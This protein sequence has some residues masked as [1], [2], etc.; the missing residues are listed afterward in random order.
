MT[1]ELEIGCD[2]AELQRRIADAVLW[3][4]TRLNLKKAKDCLRSPELAEAA[5]SWRGNGD[6]KRLAE[7]ERRA[8]IEAVADARARRVRG[9][10][11]PP[12]KAAKGKLIF[13]SPDGTW[14]DGA[15]QYVTHGFY[16]ESDMPPWD[17]W[18]CYVTEARDASDYYPS[19]LVAWMPERCAHVADDGAAITPASCIMW[20]GALDSPFTRWLKENGLA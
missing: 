19:Y 1:E 5:E 11:A 14:F 8:V 16:D 4:S 20:A 2:A 12:E 15:A 3:C 6:F 13:Y 7:A 10:P 18:L 9:L 17:T